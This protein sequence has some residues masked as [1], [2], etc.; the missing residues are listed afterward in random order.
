MSKS[1]SKM[2]HITAEVSNLLYMACICDFGTWVSW[3]C[4]CSPG[5][6]DWQ[7]YASQNL[8]DVRQDIADSDLVNSCLSAHLICP[9]FWT[10]I[11][12]RLK[13][14][15]MLINLF[16]LCTLPPALADIS[17]GMT[18]FGLCHWCRLW[19]CQRPEQWPLHH[20]QWQVKHISTKW[21]LVPAHTLEHLCF[22]FPCAT[23]TICPRLWYNHKSF[24]DCF[25]VRLSL[26]VWALSR[27][28]LNLIRD[29]A[30]NWVAT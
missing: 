17:S 8:L 7:D 20:A 14:C 6:F 4:D 30:I 26:L 15:H 5:C 25:I 18:V 27:Y 22:S 21:F 1:L 10:V 12:I 3:A 23:R 13:V 11:V 19:S 24:T 28:A 16:N 29:F 2:A 9:G